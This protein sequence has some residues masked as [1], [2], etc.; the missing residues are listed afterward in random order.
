MVVLSPPRGAVVEIDAGRDRGRTVGSFRELEVVQ[1][2][3]MV[4][5]WVIPVTARAGGGGRTK[6]GRKCWSRRIKMMTEIPGNWFATRKGLIRVPVGDHRTLCKCLR[7]HAGEASLRQPG[8][9]PNGRI[10]AINGEFPASHSPEKD[11]P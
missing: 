5:W 6:K 1:Y 10:V 7:G 2:S 4:L 11:P 9:R 8:I 3:I